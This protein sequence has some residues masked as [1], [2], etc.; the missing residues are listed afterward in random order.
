MPAFPAPAPAP[1]QPA[2]PAAWQPDDDAVDL[3]SVAGLPVLKRAIPVAA[4]LI[5]VAVVALL[6]RR[7]RRCPRLAPPRLTRAAKRVP[8]WAES[9]EL[10]WYS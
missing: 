10:G 8:G 9:L 7:R 3:L 1:A 4:G 2:A 5:A 6:R